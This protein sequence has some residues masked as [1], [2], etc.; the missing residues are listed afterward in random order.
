MTMIHLTGPENRYEMA[1][2]YSSFHKYQFHHVN[3]VVPLYYYKWRK[4][5]QMLTLP[6]AKTPLRYSNCNLYI[7]LWKHTYMQLHMYTCIWYVAII[8]FHIEFSCEFKTTP[9]RTCSIS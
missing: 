3:S 5:V 7:S 1:L 8:L 9:K 2:R 6:N 4:Y